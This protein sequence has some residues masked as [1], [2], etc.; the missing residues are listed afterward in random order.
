[1]IKIIIF[2]KSLQ[3]KCSIDVDKIDYIQRDCY[4]VGIGLSE[5]Y[6]RLLTMCRV[7][8]FN[9]NQ[10]LAWLDKLQGEIVL[11]LKHDTDYTDA[12]TIIEL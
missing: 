3:I 6:D 2:I 7:V 4:H 5:K 1:M 10:V 9:G 11:Y 12:F 8:E